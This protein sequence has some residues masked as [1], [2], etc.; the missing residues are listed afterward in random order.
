VKSIFVFIGALLF[1]GALQAG[2]LKPYDGMPLPDFTLT[3]MAGKAHK[4]SGHHGKVVMVNFWAT[5]CGPCIREMPSMARLKERLAGR[6][7]EILAINMAEEKADVAA[8]MRRHGIE[9]NFPILLDNEGMVIEQWMVS[10][11][12]TTFIVDP[13]GKIRYALYGGL[14]W[15][16][17][18]VVGTITSLLQ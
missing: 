12:P 3:D 9:V 10:A 8:F 7:F 4:L 13:Q 6:P 2:E 11:V 1:A 15:D 5:Y 18:E 14:E 17:D 16:S